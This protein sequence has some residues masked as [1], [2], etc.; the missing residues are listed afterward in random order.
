MHFPVPP[1]LP[2][3]TS[4]LT[5]GRERGGLGKPKDGPQMGSALDKKGR[6][7]GMDKGDLK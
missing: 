3:K 5:D 1:N 4:F 2:T 7:A 6:F